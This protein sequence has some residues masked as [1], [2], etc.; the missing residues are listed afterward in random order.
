MKKILSILVTL[1]L[2][3]GAAVNAAATP[4]PV[5]LVQVTPTTYSASVGDDESTNTF[6]L[7]FSAIPAGLTN[8]TAFV[9]ANF[10]GGTGYDVTGVSFDG[11]SFTAVVNFIAGNYGI[12]V[13]SYQLDNVSH[14]QHSLVVTGIEMGES[15]TGFSASLGLSNTPTLLPTV[16]VSS[17]AEP[18]TSA[19]VLA[20]LGVMGLVSRRR[21]KT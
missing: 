15:E 20:G 7:D 5:S 8:L 4:I 14:G 11:V 6:S 1:A 9:T 19:M 12:D 13:W 17:I 18:G 10:A 16:I 21:R 2:G 3:C